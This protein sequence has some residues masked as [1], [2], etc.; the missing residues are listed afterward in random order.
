MKSKICAFRAGSQYSRA[1]LSHLFHA[2]ELLFHRLATAHNLQHYLD[3][4]RRA[5]AAILGGAFPP[6]PW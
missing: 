5:R 4:A 2:E 3:L 1:Y 6:S